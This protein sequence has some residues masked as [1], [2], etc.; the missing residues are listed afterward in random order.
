MSSTAKANSNRAGATLAKNQK[1][2]AVSIRS[3][4]NMP[5]HDSTA[6]IRSYRNGPEREESPT[7]RNMILSAN[8]KML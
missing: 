8:P 7:S 5:G 3:G 4:A 1:R 6:C 2:F